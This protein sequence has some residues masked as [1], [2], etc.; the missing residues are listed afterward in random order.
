[1][2]ECFKA[3][4]GKYKDEFIPDGRIAV[5]LE[6]EGGFY[7]ALHTMKNKFENKNTGVAIL[8]FGGGTYDL[9]V[10]KFQINQ[11]PEIIISDYGADV[12]GSDVDKNFMAIIEQITEFSKVNIPDKD[13]SIIWC[14]TL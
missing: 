7:Y 4:M 6:P 14:N 9:T 11:D 5:V 1:M 10:G 8:D 12:G 3:G 2:R 13:K